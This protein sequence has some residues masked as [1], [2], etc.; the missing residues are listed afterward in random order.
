MITNGATDITSQPSRIDRRKQVPFSAA[1]ASADIANPAVIADIANLAVIADIANL[2]VIAD[3]ANSAV[4][5]DIANLAVIA[6][7]GEMADICLRMS[8]REEATSH[9]TNQ[10]GVSIQEELIS[11]KG[12]V[13]GVRNRVRTSVSKHDNQ[14]LCKTDEEGKI[15]LYS[16]SVSIV[17]STY[18]N[19]K[20]VINILQN[21]RL[22]YEL[23]DVSRN[24]LY[25]EELEGRL[26]EEE[27]T[28]PQLFAGGWWIGN[29]KRVQELNETGELSHL[30]ENYPKIEHVSFY[31]EDCGGYRYVPCPKCQGTKKS[32][33][34]DSNLT[35]LRCTNCDKQGLT[36]C[37]SCLEQQE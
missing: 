37:T 6:D 31:C 18:Q 4:I 13:R 24:R 14:Q 34:V 27:M 3:I 7:I 23:R 1:D 33:M 17:R 8:V 30:L 19:C 9:G 2:A 11:E 25:Q 15:V 29:A 35:S 22:R 20:E 26:N 32:T 10:M 5:A 28:L 16:T 36:R 21:H 12:T